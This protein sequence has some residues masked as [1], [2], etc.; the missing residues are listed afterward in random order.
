MKC[1]E[2]GRQIPEGAL[3]CKYCGARAE[4]GEAADGKKLNFEKGQKGVRRVAAK[5]GSGL[6]IALVA[7][8]IVAIGV[9][10]A[11]LIWKNNTPEP[12]PE[13]TQTPPATEQTDEQT[14]PETWTASVLPQDSEV[15]VGENLMLNAT[16]DQELGA[17][18][19]RSITW[20]SSDPSVATVSDGIVYGI[21]AGKTTI[22]AQLALS[23]GSS[24]ECKTTVTVA[25]ASVTYT[26]V[27]SPE[28]VTMRPGDTTTLIA[29]LEQD[30]AE[31]VEVVS[32]VWTSSNKDVAVV[33]NGKVSAVGIGSATISVTIN[34]SSGP[35]ASANAAITVTANQPAGGTTGTTSGNTGT[36]AGGGT[37][38]V[39]GGSNSGTVT[40]GST[41]GTTSGGN[42]GGGGNYSTYNDY[43]LPG[44]NS[45]L[46]SYAT[47]QSLS[48]WELRVARNEIY[49]RH[50]RLFNNADLQAHFNSKSWYKGTIAPD[51]FDASVLNSV[52]LENIDRIKEVEASR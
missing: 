13:D 50:G 2:C 8:L 48:D 37:G 26:A 51:A 19:V 43:V 12:A 10:A 5:K 18:Q 27:I 20:Q 30:L 44:S 40:G 38:T 29:D 47:L 36:T 31:G 41:G 3:F 28:A 45:S 23:D 16:V 4:S 42:A 21:G 9:L 24:V 52:E 32:T 33:S 39:T 15:E 7:I 25:E 11:V 46:Y 34:L 6:I 49:A 17:V 35:A 22:T 14:T 1:K